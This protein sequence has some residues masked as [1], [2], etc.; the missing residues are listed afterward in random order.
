M[1][2]YTSFQSSVMQ[3]PSNNTF[4]L[5]WEFMR[6]KE[7]QRLNVT[8][9]SERDGFLQYVQ[10]LSLKGVSGGRGKGKSGASRTQTENRQQETQDNTKRPGAFNGDFAESQQD[11]ACC[12]LIMGL[13][14]LVT[15]R[16]GA[17]VDHNHYQPL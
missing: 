5:L 2:N 11:T 14:F 8:S 3:E 6:Q 17:L 12:L 16:I 9:Q 1:Q 10:P 13:L 4:S 7:S 15:C